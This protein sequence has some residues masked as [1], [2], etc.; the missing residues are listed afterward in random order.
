ME[1]P[2]EGKK[3]HRFPSVSSSSSSSSNDAEERE[4]NK[5]K[6]QEKMII[7]DDGWIRPCLW[8]YLR[9]IVEEPQ[10]VLVKK[11]AVGQMAEGQRD[12]RHNSLTEGR[13]DFVVAQRQKS[14]DINV[15]PIIVIAATAHSGRRRARLLVCT[16]GR[17]PRPDSIRS[18]SS[19]CHH[20]TIPYQKGHHR[21]R[22]D[23]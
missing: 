3:G 23:D 9:V 5:R 18:R 4:E 7:K 13:L 17:R 10:S 12:G 16:S 14:S 15:L 1:H 19:R 8:Q 21:H 22:C 6:R 11:S 20:D 2:G